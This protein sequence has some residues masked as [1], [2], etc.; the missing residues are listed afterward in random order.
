M[1]T[2]RILF[3]LTLLVSSAV[4][5]YSCTNDD[6]ELTPEQKL[7]RQM[8]ATWVAT[9][10]QLDDVAAE[11]YTDFSIAFT[12][13][14]NYSVEG[15]PDRLPFPTSGAWEFGT[16]ITEF[17]ILATGNQDLQTQYDLTDTTLTIEF[18][19]SGDGF[20]NA[21]TKGLTGNWV[22]VFEKN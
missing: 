17:L 19:Y 8:A 21:R 6:N 4:T 13:T 18:S 14:L 1:K 11:G 9:S 7:V 20:V 5:F 16:P 10:V 2:R 22:F 12:G 3:A 15:G